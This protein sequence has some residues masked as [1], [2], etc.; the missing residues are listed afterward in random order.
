MI[1]V[2]ALPRHLAPSA[3]GPAEL[4][5]RLNAALVAD[6]P[7]RLFVT[8]VCGVYDARDGSVVLAS[9]G[10]PG[11]LLRR[12]DGAVEEVALKNGALLGQFPVPPRLSDTTLSLQPGETLVLYTDGMTE[13]FAPDG[14]TM[15]GLDRLREALG[16][17][18]AR[19]SLEECAAAACAA[20]ERFTGQP[21]LQDDQ[22]LLLLRRR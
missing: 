10:H 6:N 12:A 19:L 15:F 1:A 11:P 20:V 13:A 9:G 2:R 22:T 3:A 5:R 18:R 16:G 8:L 21:E 14:K 4:L 17:P 7:T